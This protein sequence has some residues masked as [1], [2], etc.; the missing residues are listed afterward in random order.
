MVFNKRRSRTEVKK[1]EKMPLDRPHSNEHRRQQKQKA[2]PTKNNMECID[3]LS[4][5][6]KFPG[7]A[8]RSEPLNNEKQF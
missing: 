5:M 4:P 3:L 7:M 8:Q 6:P 2:R 1:M